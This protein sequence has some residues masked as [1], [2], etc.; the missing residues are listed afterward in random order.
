MICE[1]SIY[2]IVFG[3]FLILSFV[4]TLFIIYENLSKSG[5]KLTTAVF[6]LLL[7]KID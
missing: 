5:D 7:L 4:I 3:C 2:R 1:K 6:T